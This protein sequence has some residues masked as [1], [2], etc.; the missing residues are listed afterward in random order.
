LHEGGLQNARRL[1]AHVAGTK[2]VRKPCGETAGPRNAN[3]R[4]L[5]THRIRETAQ[6]S[7]GSA[8]PFASSLLSLSAAPIAYLGPDQRRVGKTLY[9]VILGVSDVQ[10]GPR[11]PGEVGGDLCSKLRIFRTIGGQ[12]WPV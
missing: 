9:Q 6:T 5:V 1:P 10:L 2:P 7:T 3:A 4:W 8:P 11:P 12:Q